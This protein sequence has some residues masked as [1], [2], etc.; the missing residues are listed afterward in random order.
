MARRGS[1]AAADAAAAAARRHRDER[2]RDVLRKRG[3]EDKGSKSEHAHQGDKEAHTI[4]TQISLYLYSYV[5]Y[6]D[7]WRM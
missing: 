2:R 3:C 1:I 4:V 6:T 5:L 7:I